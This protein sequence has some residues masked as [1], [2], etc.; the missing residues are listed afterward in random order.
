MA[1]WDV[2]RLR[3]RA[4]NTWRPSTGIDAQRGDPYSTQPQISRALQT[5]ADPGVNLQGWINPYS[6]TFYS[7]L[8]NTNNPV[9]CAPPNLRRAYLILQNQGPGN[10]YLNFGQ[11]ATAPNS[12]SN[13]NCMQLIT[14]QFYEQIGGGS[15]DLTTGL[16]IAGNFVSPDYVSAITDTATTTLLVGE[17]VFMLSRWSGTSSQ[18]N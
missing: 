7:V 9:Q 15:V 18:G 3:A 6:L 10:I 11:S 8:L 12:A 4:G 2:A 13:A 16:P 17:G 5:P 1:N 14:T